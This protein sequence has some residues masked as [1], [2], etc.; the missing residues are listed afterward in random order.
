MHVA[1]EAFR[2][3]R[4]DG[5]L[6]QYAMLVDV[7]W[8]IADFPS[9]GS[10]G[11]FA[12]DDCDRPHWGFAVDGDTAIVVGETRQTVPP[13]SA[14]HIPAGLPHRIVVD[15]TA[16]LAGFERVPESG[17]ADENAIREAGF[18]IVKPRQDASIA[19]ARAK[20]ERPP[21]D[22]EILGTTR[23]MGDLLF[24]RARLGRKAGYTSSQCDVPH[25]GLVVSGSLAIEGEDSIEVVTAGDVFACPAG[26]PGHR[27][28]AA[29][30]AVIVDFTPVEALEKATRVAEWRRPAA[31]RALRTSPPPRVEVA[32]LV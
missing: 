19:I 9:T 23:R 22:G 26:P 12:E 18:E 16:R 6:L 14:F 20:P 5:V 15:G 10:R 11:T 2:A 32:A 4:R 27:L 17:P 29:D 25:W 21:D 3:V 7:A 30:P 31:V 24:T 28:Q 8:V 13:G 1:P